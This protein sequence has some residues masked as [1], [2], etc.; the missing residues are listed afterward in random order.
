MGKCECTFQ[1]FI[2]SPRA[3][4]TQADDRDITKMQP[5]NGYVQDQTEPISSAI[6][7]LKRNV[8]PTH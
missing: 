8:Q 4:T 6:N 1:A 2:K 7:G 5:G 3:L